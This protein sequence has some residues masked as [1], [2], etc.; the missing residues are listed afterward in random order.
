[1]FA[2]ALQDPFDP[3]QLSNIQPGLLK[4]LTEARSYVLEISFAFRIQKQGDFFQGKSEEAQGFN[5]HSLL[6][7]GNGVVPLSRKRVLCFRNKQPFPVI[8]P[9][10]FLGEASHEGKLTDW[11]LIY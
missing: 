6:Q 10:R 8:E 4:F 3:L 2:G 9:E 11:N 1:V 7:L 5:F